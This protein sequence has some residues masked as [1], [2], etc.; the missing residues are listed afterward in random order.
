MPVIPFRR[1][2]I[3]VLPDVQLAREMTWVHGGLMTGARQK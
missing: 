1:N 2:S 3:N